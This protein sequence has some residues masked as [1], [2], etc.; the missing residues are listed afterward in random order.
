MATRLGVQRWGYS[1]G[2]RVRVGVGMAVGLGVEGWGWGGGEGW[3]WGCGEGVT[4]GRVG[5]EVVM[6]GRLWG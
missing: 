2:V 3:G 6:A 4:E 1:G 5:G